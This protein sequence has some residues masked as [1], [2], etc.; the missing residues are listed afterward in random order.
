MDVPVGDVWLDF[1]QQVCRGFVNADEGAVVELPKSQQS[2][3]AD[4]SGIKLVDT[5]NSDHEGDLRL[6][7][8]VDLPVQLGSPFNFELIGGSLLV[9]GSR[10]LK[11]LQQQFPLGLVLGSTFLAQVLESGCNF[12]VSLLFLPEPFRFGGHFL[13][14]LHLYPQSN[15][16]N[17]KLKY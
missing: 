6:G 13:L 11:S 4:R 9:V 8:H 16:T 12:L 17:I 14:S 10:L 15:I 1:S 7:R 3:D 5:A 2:E